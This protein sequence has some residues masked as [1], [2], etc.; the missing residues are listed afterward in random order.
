MM[1]KVLTENRDNQSLHR[2]Q[3]DTLFDTPPQYSPDDLVALFAPSASSLQT[4]TTKFRK[5]FVGPIVVV[6]R[7]PDDTYLLKDPSTNQLLPSKYPVVRLRP[8]KEI[9]NQGVATSLSALR[10]AASQADKA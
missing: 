3:A 4:N 6:R 2:F 5:D 10:E 8:W 1:I 7:Y 9:T